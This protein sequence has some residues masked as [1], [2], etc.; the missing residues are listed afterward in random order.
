MYKQNIVYIVQKRRKL[1]LRL[2]PNSDINLNFLSIGKAYFRIDIAANN[3]KL[4]NAV[5]KEVMIL[6][7]HD[8]LF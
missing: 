4:S 5:E 6:I 8:N 2:R 3:K 1:N 7:H